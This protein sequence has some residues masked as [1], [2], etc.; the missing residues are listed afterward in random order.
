MYRIC[1]LGFSVVGFGCGFGVAFFSALNKSTRV[2]PFTFWRIIF[3]EYNFSL[4]S[5]DYRN[6]AG[7]VL[8]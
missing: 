7:R 2:S 6:R 3:P 1:G 5:V 4:I 8:L